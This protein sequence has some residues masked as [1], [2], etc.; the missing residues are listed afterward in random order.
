MCPNGTLVGKGLGT[1][2]KPC[3]RPYIANSITLSR[4]ILV[5]SVDLRS[6]GVPGVEMFT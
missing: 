1:N 3:L 4:Q 5:I 6:M 2:G